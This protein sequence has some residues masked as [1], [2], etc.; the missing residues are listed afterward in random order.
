MTGLHYLSIGDDPTHSCH[1]YGL[2]LCTSKSACF[3]HKNT[4]TSI[5][6][7]GLA[8]LSTPP[9]IELFNFS[10]KAQPFMHP[11]RQAQASAL[12]LGVDV[13]SLISVLLFQILMNSG[14]FQSGAASQGLSPSVTTATNIPVLLPVTPTW[15]H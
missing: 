1:G 6:E 11:S 3:Y 14:L 2:M 10:H 8:T 13:N 5:Q 15:I 4:L 9:N 7:D 12:S